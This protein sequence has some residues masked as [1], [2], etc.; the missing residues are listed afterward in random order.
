[1]IKIWGDKK[2]YT[3]TALLLGSL[4]AF[5]GCD[6]ELDQIEDY[7]G[8]TIETT[9][10]EKSGDEKSG[11]EDGGSTEIFESS[12]VGTLDEKLGGKT[13]DFNES[14]DAKG[15]NVNI[16][17]HYDV[18][19]V[20]S[21]PTYRITPI[22]SES[23]REDDIVKNIFGDSASPIVPDKRKYISE[24]FEDSV[25]LIQ[26]AINIQYH[27]GKEYN[28]GNTS[29]PAWTDDDGYFLHTYEGQYMGKDYELVISYSDK[30]REMGVI[31]FPK[32]ISDIIG[33]TECDN[34]SYTGNDGIL[35]V[36]NRGEV[37]SYDIREMMKDKPNEST[38]PAEELT[39]EIYKTMQDDLYI[40]LP[41]GGVSLSDN[42][43]YEHYDVADEDRAEDDRCELVFFNEMMLEGNDLQDAVRHGYAAPVMLN[44]GK[45]N[46]IPSVDT[47]DPDAD[48]LK[49]GAAFVD[50]NG[51]IGLEFVTSYSFNEQLSDNVILINFDNAMSAL[52]EGISKNVDVAR[53]LEGSSNSNL[54]FN[55]I[56]LMYYPLESPDKT[57]CTYVPA[58]VV[59]A[60]SGNM[61]D[62]RVVINAVD[63]TYITTIYSE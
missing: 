14:I 25:P 27:N 29:C 52:K 58:W 24:A 9:S 40:G 62:A 39:D 50:D 46:F 3:I 6:K 45:I 38:R 31:L 63:G 19:D 42:I 44:I 53:A 17:L 34:F 4:M 15:Y 18:P 41:E 5:N 54:T 33:E 48:D 35:Y 36:Y 37:K 10:A 23:I 57:E 7:G 56:E 26:A 28:W 32:K 16:N 8:E 2:R 22:T 55:H 30:Y 1:M 49:V 11:G 61:I 51:V 20:Q 21:V 12:T 43:Y 47:L 60:G 59:D 13:F